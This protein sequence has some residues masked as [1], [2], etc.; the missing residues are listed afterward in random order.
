MNEWLPEIDAWRDAGENVVT[1]TVVNVQGSAPRPVGA[2]LAVNP[3]GD[4]AGSVSGGCVESAVVISALEVMESGVGRLEHFGIS[5]EMAWD[6]GLSC[7]GVIDVWIQ[8]LQPQSAIDEARARQKAG[9]SVALVTWLDGTNRQIVTSE[10]AWEQSGLHNWDGS[11][12][13]VEIFPTVKQLVI[14]GAVHT[15][16]PLSRYAQDL[17]FDVVIVDARKALATKERFPNVEKILTVWPDD[18]YEQLTITDST[19]IAILSHDPK[20]DEPAILGALNT[21]AAYI[22]T[23]GSRKTN[24]DR[25]ERLRNAGVSEKQIERLHGPIGLNIGGKSPEEM[26]ISILAE[27][28]AIENGRDGAMLKSSTGSITG[29]HT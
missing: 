20:F 9:E 11:Q 4:M 23:V 14:F 26:A 13:Y 18:A 22:G 24:A 17:G 6:V 2:R 7:G 12:V 15:A 19:W 29:A 3:D 25:R 21:N 5:D 28:I 1:A 16:Q 10:F 8:P 27:M